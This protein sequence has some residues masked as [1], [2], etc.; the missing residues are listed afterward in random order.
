LR[1]A[2]KMNFEQ[3]K[4]NLNRNRAEMSTLQNQ[5]ATMKRVTKP[6]D[7]PLAATRSLAARSDKTNLD[8]FLKNLN[9]AK[10]FLEF[11]DQS[12]AE[13]TNS[14][15]RLKELA[16]SQASDAS[17]N[18][19]S[20]RTVATEVKQ[21]FAQLVQMG[22][23]KFGDRYIFGGYKTTKP[24][25][26]AEGR[27]KG[28]DGQMQIEVIGGAYLPMNTP[29]SAVFLGKNLAINTTSQTLEDPLLHQETIETQQ[30]QNNP[31]N[32]VLADRGPESATMRAPASAQTQQQEE[33]NYVR[34]NSGNLNNTPGFGGG[35]N[36]FDVVKQLEIGLMTSDTPTIQD[37]LERLDE[38][39]SQ[40]VMARA[41][42]GSR[43]SALDSNRD[44]IQKGQVESK[45]TISNLEDANTFELL[46]DIKKNETTLQATLQT[47]GKLLQGSLLDFLR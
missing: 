5:A 2:D 46:S 10:S 13:V 45:V 39:V 34:Y 29:G 44:L 21:I 47:S 36:I 35:E 43:V 24:P 20:R 1:V 26:S 37:S 17:S 28:D 42:I 23:R 32:N 38:A 12:L 31:P 25:F 18:A 22:N 3:V 30:Q 33:P 14:L 16:L 9:M 4:R 11:S 27:Y 15:V 19:I 41:Q 6:S 7:D 40:V 8:Q